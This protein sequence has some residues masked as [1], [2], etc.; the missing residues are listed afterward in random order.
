MRRKQSFFLLVSL[1]LLLNAADWD[2]SRQIERGKG[3]YAANCTSC[4]GVRAEGGLRFE[5]RRSPPAL[6]GKGHVTHHSPETLLAHIRKGGTK[7][8]EWM[9]AFEMRL[10][11]KEQ[12]AV[13][14][15]LYSLWP[16]KTWSRYEKKFPLKSMKES[17]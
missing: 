2:D 8:G 16:R 15:Y 7:R 10:D 17:R 4:H 6:N 13:L 12:K 1:P 9:P 11:S 3:L 5:G 14:A